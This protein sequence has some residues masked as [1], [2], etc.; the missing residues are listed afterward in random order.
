[1]PNPARVYD[2]LLGGPLRLSG[3]PLGQISGNTYGLGSIL[4]YRRM[5]RTQSVIVKNLYLG[6]S[7][8]AG[9]AWLTHADVTLTDMKTAGSV[10]AIADT[11]LGPLVFAYGRSGGNASFYVFLNRPF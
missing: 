5:T 6:V 8:E 11:L 2:F 1:M 9:N 4:L 7:A 10:F 3:R